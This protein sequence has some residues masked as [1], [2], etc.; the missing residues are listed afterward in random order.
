MASFNRMECYTCRSVENADRGQ[1]TRQMW[2]MARE[3]TGEPDSK[4]GRIQFEI[5]KCMLYRRHREFLKDDVTMQFMV[6]Q[7]MV[8]ERLR[9]R[10]LH[11][12]HES[13]MSAH[14]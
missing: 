1:N 2:K 12:V 10:V 9:S 14:Q 13:L 4:T 7:F 11:A 3:E 5:K 8:P 6:P